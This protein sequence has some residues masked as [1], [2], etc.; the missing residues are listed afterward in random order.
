MCCCGT[1]VFTIKTCSNYVFKLV[2]CGLRVRI[3]GLFLGLF[4]IRCLRPLLEDYCGKRDG[5]PKFNG[6]GG[7]LVNGANQEICQKSD[8]VFSRFPTQ[9]LARI[10]SENEQESGSEMHRD[11][12]PFLLEVHHLAPQEPRFCRAAGRRFVSNFN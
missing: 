10:G 6:G 12:G 11:P 3:A 4:F 2:S 1:H 8:F 7:P 9:K 5:A